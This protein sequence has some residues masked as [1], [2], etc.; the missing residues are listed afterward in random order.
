MV[1]MLSQIKALSGEKAPNILIEKILV[2]YD[3]FDQLIKYLKEKQ[4]SRIVMVADDNTYIAAG[5]KLEQKIKDNGVSYSVTL[6][7][8]DNNGDVLADEYSIVQVLTETPQD[9]DVVLVAGSGTIHDVVRFTCYKMNKPFISIPTAP[10]VD[11]FTSMGAPI[12][13]RGFKITYQ[14]KSPI[15]VFADLDVLQHAPRKMIAA[16]FGDM[17][18]KFTS[19]TDWHFGHLAAGEPYSETAAR[20]TKEALDTCVANIDTISK[21]DEAGIRVLFEAL[22]KSGLAMLMFGQSHPASG[23]EHHLSHYW[24]MEFLKRHKPQVLHGAKV[25]VSTALLSD[26]YKTELLPVLSDRARLEKLYTTRDEK[27]NLKRILQHRDKIV[28]LYSNI[29]D[30]K[31]IRDMISKLGGPVYPRDLDIDR[32]L[33]AESLQNAHH[34][35]NR[36]TGLKFLNEIVRMGEHELEEI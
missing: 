25:S 10:S 9:A 17:M 11:G 14:T 24:E 26:I 27:E 35:R 1:D 22:V 19:L 2:S 16:G 15:A 13:I 30:A 21:A 28:A 33:V 6:L 20:I 8:P 12:V 31:V 3:A 34:L 32:G 23:G 36:F 7:K 18:A 5:R 29:P 4:W